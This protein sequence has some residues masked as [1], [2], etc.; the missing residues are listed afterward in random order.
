MKYTNLWF[1]VSD[2]VNL[3]LR[4][5]WHIMMDK[6]SECQWR[7]GLGSYKAPWGTESKEIV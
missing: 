5:W 4:T 3:W 2:H 6:G 1:T 7:P